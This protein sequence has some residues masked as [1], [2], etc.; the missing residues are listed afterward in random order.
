MSKYHAAFEALFC[1]P[2]TFSINRPF[3][4]KINKIIEIFGKFG[5][6]PHL[7]WPTLK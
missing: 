4:E 1:G 6:W 7:G 2:S 3:R 5:P